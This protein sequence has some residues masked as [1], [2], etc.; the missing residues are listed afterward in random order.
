[1]KLLLDEMISPKI[2][3]E[4]GDRGDFDVLHQRLHDASQQGIDP[5]LGESSGESLDGA[6]GQRRAEE[7][8][9]ASPVSPDGMSCNGLAGAG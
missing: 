4:L 8:R 7:P 1:M 2:A 6:P 9:S 5:A 3:R